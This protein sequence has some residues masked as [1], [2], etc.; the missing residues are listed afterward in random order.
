MGA[1]TIQAC[2]KWRRRKYM[3]TITNTYAKMQLDVHT[4]YTYIYVRNTCQKN[5]NCQCT[6][7][8]MDDIRMCVQRVHQ[9]S[10]DSFRAAR[11]KQA[12]SFVC[13]CCSYVFADISALHSFLHHICATYHSVTL[14]RNLTLFVVR[15][16]FLETV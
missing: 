14:I 5:A 13:A 6:H 2:N 10:C 4:V 9:T 16:F 7:A 8:G 12:I 3:Y 15:Y 11:A 1:R